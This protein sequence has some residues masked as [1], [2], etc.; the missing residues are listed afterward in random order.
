MQALVP[1]A[2]V[3][4][5]SSANNDSA[6]SNSAVNI[7][8]ISTSAKKLFLQHSHKKKKEMDWREDDLMIWCCKFDT[9]FYNPQKY[10]ELPQKIKIRPCTLH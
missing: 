5:T 2:P 1:A 3:L 10:T 8:A 9:S 6:I 7:S 4:H